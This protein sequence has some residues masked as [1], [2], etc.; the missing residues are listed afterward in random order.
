MTYNK[1]Y[2][3]IIQ[4][5]KKEKIFQMKFDE[6]DVMIL[7]ELEKNSRLS[8]RELSKRINLSPSSVTE[9]VKRLEDNRIIEGYT[10]TINKKNLGL[11]ID[12]IIKITMKNG[13]YE[14][15]KNFIKDYNRSEWC[16]RIAGDG[17][18]LVKLSVKDLS[19]IEEF[20]NEVSPYATTSTYIAFSEVVI[21]NSINKFLI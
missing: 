18:F 1:T 2:I 3:Y 11:S 10:I 8:I 5:I 6:I 9:R 14:P 15:F 16:Y 13:E 21:E 12:C 17:C 7:S 4:N 19:D 20:I